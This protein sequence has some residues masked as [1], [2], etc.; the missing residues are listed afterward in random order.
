MTL[1]PLGRAVLLFGTAGLLAVVVLLYL[2]A[3]VF[4]LDARGVTRMTWALLICWAIVA[5]LGI[6]PVV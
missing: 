2:A 4:D 3:M 6:A 5:V 1:S